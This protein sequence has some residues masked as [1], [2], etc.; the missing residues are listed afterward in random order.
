MI[1][2]ARFFRKTHLLGWVIP[3]QLFHIPYIVV[4]GW[5][6]KFGSY[7]WKGRKVN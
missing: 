4:A 1:P 2:I 3:G 5:L 7:Q 6:G